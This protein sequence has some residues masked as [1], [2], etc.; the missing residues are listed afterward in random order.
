MLCVEDEFTRE[1][2]AI[3]VD[4]KLSS[5]EVLET[6]AEL[7]LEPGVPEHIRFDNGPEFVAQ[8]VRDW[9]AAVRSNTGQHLT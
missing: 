6:L 4:R 1:T 5:T 7:M 9:I 2:L 3:K 8:A